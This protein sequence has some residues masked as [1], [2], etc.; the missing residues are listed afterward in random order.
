MHT[1]I[2]VYNVCKAQKPQNF[3]RESNKSGFASF[4]LFG[5][6]KSKGNIYTIY[7]TATKKFSN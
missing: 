1:N 7:K 2:P 5:V 3:N 6:G 4:K